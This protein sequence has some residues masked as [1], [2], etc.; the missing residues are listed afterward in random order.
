MSRS[1]N[2]PPQSNHPALNVR[3]RD[4]LR[5]GL[6]GFALQDV[7]LR[8][9]QAESERST[10]VPPE[11]KARSCVFIF[12]FGG[13]SHIDL[14]DLKPNAPLEIRGDFQSI[15]TAS[16]NVRICEHLP[17]LAQ[18]MERFCLL[19]SMTHRMP[20]HGPACSEIYSGRPY[21][22]APVTDQA[23]E[24]D[25]PSIA[26]LVHRFG[27][28]GN[29]ARADGRLPHSIVLPWYT[30]F[31]GQDKRIAGQ[32]GARMGEQFNPFLVEGNL[33]DPEF[34]VR[35]LRLPGEVSVN[36]FSRR[37][38]LRSQ[39]EPHGLSEAQQ[40]FQTRVAEGN[41][42][43][44]AA[45]VERTEAAGVL[46]LSREP[47]SMRNR[48]GRTRFGQSLLMARR[49]VEADVSLIT[50]NW[51]DDHKD[52]K[53]SPHWDTHVDNFPKLKDRLCPPFDRAMSTLLADLD[54]RGLLESTLVVALGEFG[55]SPK[56]GLVTQNGMTKK[57]GRDHW[58]HAFSAMVAGGGVRGGQAFGATTRNGGYV[59]DSPVT[60]ADLSATVFQ[61]LGID[62][63]T[64]YQDHF[65]QTR[66]PLTTGQPVDL[67]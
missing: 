3:R 67:G 10:S 56:I 24:E 19:R 23:R 13:P 30:Q 6:G 11:Q 18:Q 57:T 40:T 4:V 14:W 17:L 39:L 27:R 38:S 1:E 42:E 8:Q 52:D 34:H 26:S 29:S 45:L 16:P 9:L 36:R 43:A 66:Q 32:T 37:R 47:D 64:R 65:L 48:Y 58:P 51:D 55:R 49:L 63:S 54:E 44:A 60:P 12:L 15:E 35:G 22:G 7:W 59:A 46:D 53:V 28:P 2:P 5:A 41:F 31:V 21:F 61:H 50:V 33:T 20:V 25:W 62:P